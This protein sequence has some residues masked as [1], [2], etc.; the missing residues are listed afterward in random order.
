MGRRWDYNGL[1]GPA[2][3]VRSTPISAEPN[4]VTLW[5]LPGIFPRVFNGFRVRRVTSF[6]A[7]VERR[8]VLML[9]ASHGRVHRAGTFRRRIRGLR[10]HSQPLALPAKAFP[11]YHFLH[12]VAS[13]WSDTLEGRSWTTRAASNSFAILANPSNATTKPC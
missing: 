1:P 2:G 7:P 12:P 10:A 5:G 8:P 6:S 11:G 13:E 9:G 4:S 3:G